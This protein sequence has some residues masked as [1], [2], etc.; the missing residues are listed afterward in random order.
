MGALSFTRN[1]A[2]RENILINTTYAAKPVNNY[3][4]STTSHH[5][6][7]RGKIDMEAPSTKQVPGQ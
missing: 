2:A 7:H 1:L 3:N 6:R 5:T 4:I